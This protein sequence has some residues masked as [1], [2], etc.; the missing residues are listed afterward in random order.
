MRAGSDR[1]SW[2]RQ[3]REACPLG[4]QKGSQGPTVAKA[5][6]GYVLPFLV[7]FAFMVLTEI[8][9]RSW[10]SS[11]SVGTSQALHQLPAATMVPSPRGLPHNISLDCILRGPAA[12]FKPPT[13]DRAEEIDWF[14]R[15]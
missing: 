1:D 12:G 13:H 15:A 6:I 2:S 9:R 3:P 4:G 10:C 5:V 11:H 7:A 8:W 14:E